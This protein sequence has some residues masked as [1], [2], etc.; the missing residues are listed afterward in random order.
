MV[1]DDAN[2]D[3][4]YMMGVAKSHHDFKKA[5]LFAVDMEQVWWVENDGMKF[6]G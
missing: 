4:V 5:R 2:P 1:G 6:P 3:R